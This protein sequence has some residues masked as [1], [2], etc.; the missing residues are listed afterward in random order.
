MSVPQILTLLASEKIGYDK[1]G[2]PVHA[3]LQPLVARTS[4]GMIEVPVGFNT[5][6]ASVPRLPVFFLVA[7]DRAHEQ[8]AVH[9]YLYTIRA[10]IGR[11]ACDKIFHELLLAGTA[12]PEPYDLRVSPLLAWSMYQAVDK[13][14]QSA[15][16]DETEI[17]QPQF[18][19]Q[20]INESQREA[21]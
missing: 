10:S 13:F 4:Y 20:R 17:R 21:P 8:A 9:D 12:I 7:G 14:G 1:R 16:D 6:F 18:V 11:A 5:N 2:R 3:I 15:W 19:I